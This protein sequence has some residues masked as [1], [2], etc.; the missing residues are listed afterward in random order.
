MQTQ[1]Q[2]FSQVP[3][4]FISE[5]SGFHELIKGP[6]MAE[7]R[8][9]SM[10]I[11]GVEGKS[12]LTKSD[13]AYGACIAGTFRSRKLVSA[14]DKLLMVGDGL[15]YISEAMD[16]E[17]NVDSDL[18]VALPGL[19][20]SPQLIAAQQQRNP[21]QT[22][23]QGDC[24]KLTEMPDLRPHG[25]IVNEVIADLPTTV[26]SKEILVDLM[27]E[28]QQGG[29]TFDLDRFMV[30]H[31]IEK[32]PDI[33]SLREVHRYCTNYGLSY[34]DLKFADPRVPIGIGGFKLL[35]QA[36]EIL[37]SGGWIWLSEFGDIEP[38]TLPTPTNLGDHIEW[39]TQ[40]DQMRK[41]AEKLGYDTEIVPLAEFI[42][43]DEDKLAII[44]RTGG[45]GEP[46]CLTLEE[47]VK[48]FPEEY[49]RSSR[50]TPR[51][52]SE[53]SSPETLSK[54][55]QYGIQWMLQCHEL[56]VGP[57]TN[58]IGELTSKDVEIIR[59]GDYFADFY[60]MLAVK[61]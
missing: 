2:D 34:P 51:F 23:T 21:W 50:F 56:G 24:L 52:N 48:N 20:I 57:N 59:I 32:K 58:Q 61:K 11:R 26:V 1:E 5:T 6:S 46:I 53:L 15:G 14:G 9:A 41:V 42:G 38:G 18:G 49:P 37:P 7:E 54:S 40:F 55:M 45:T 17:L 13:K 27:A 22:I 19:D 29:L 12:A 4:L 39:S 47:A 28:S 8:T 25:I 43:L 35:E 33:E 10:L 30:T 36:A 44:H 31:G 16:K 3:K 60:S